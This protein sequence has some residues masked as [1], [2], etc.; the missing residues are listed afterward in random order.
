MN[1]AQKTVIITGATSF[2]GMH[3]C[4]AFSKNSWRVIAAHTQELTAYT[5]PQATRID[6]IS[7]AMEFE[8]ID[9][10]DQED[11]T[12]I[13]DKYAPALW[14][15]HAG[16]ATNYA[17]ADY[18]FENGL[19]VNAG[20]IATLFK[21][22]NNK[23]C[24]TIIT[25]TEAEYGPADDAHV[26]TDLAKPNSLYGL[27]KLTQ[28]NTA[29]QQSEYYG[30]PTRVARLFLP[31]G[32]LDHPGKVISLVIDALK[33]NTSIDL[34]SCTQK[35]DFIGVKDICDAYLK[36]ADDLTRGGF[37][38]FN[39]CSGEATELSVVLKMI[40]NSI[41]VDQKLLNFG[42]IPKR[43]GETELVLGNNNKAIELLSWHPRQLDIAI[44]EELNLVA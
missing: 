28:T 3:L 23:Q 30:I 39:L 42:K 5:E 25:S 13:V 8:K 9:I 17:S 7:R 20:S 6:Q 32:S 41:G 16:F 38:I 27:A 12:R 2:I 33:N 18:D 1:S 26:E 19:K 35:R 31:F 10:C 36:L 24:G 14:I 21:V 40:A 37:D 44:K 22:L 4:S 34:S 29:R 15:Q 11:L 43:E